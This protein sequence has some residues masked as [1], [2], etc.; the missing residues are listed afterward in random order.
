MTK[1]NINNYR[2]KVL[3]KKVLP[4]ESPGILEEFLFPEGLPEYLPKLK[5]SPELLTIFH[6]LFSLGYNSGI[7]RMDGF[8]AAES[9][10]GTLEERMRLI[11]GADTR[12]I[13]SY[14][15]HTN[16]KIEGMEHT[17][18]AELPLYQTPIKARDVRIGDLLLIRRDETTVKQ[19][20]VVELQILTNGFFNSSDDDWRIFTG[21]QVD[22]MQITRYAT[23]ERQVVYVKNRIDKR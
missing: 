1:K 17:P 10:T 20:G 5:N 9:T 7:G 13:I 3:Q 11:I 22:T 15:C 14:K 12:S 4:G 18:M 23:K 8:E 21:N 19:Q 6:L 16:F 2:P